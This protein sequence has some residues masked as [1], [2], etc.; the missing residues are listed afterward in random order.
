VNRARV[1]T[2][3]ALLIALSISGVVLA[4]ASGGSGAVPDAAVT[5]PASSSLLLAEVETGGASASDEFVEVTNAGAATADLVGLEVAYV[6]ST[7]GTITRKAS[8]ASSRPLA[9]GQHLLIA[10]A[11][12]IYGSLADV[13]YSGGLAAT[14]GALVLRPIGGAPIDAIAWGDA[15]NAFVEG[16]AAPAPAASASIEREPGG[17]DGNTT[18]TNSNVADWF[19]Q[20]IPNPQSLS[21]PPVPAP[22]PSATPTPTPSAGASPSTTPAPTDTPA[23]SPTASA[24]SSAEPSATPEPSPSPTAVP[25]PTPVPTPTVESTL[26]PTP[27]ATPEPTQTPAPT[28]APTPTPI[29]TPI[30]TD[31]PLPSPTPV[32]TDIAAVRLQA[33]GTTATVQGVLTTQ[34]GALEAGRKA[35]IQDATAGIALYLD[36]AVSDGLAAGTS[37]R[38]TGTLDDRYAERTLRANLADVIVLGD[39]T[40]PTPLATTSGSIGEALE[41]TRVTVDGLTVGSPSPLADG[42]GILVD[43]GSGA[44]RAI[45]GSEALGVAVL[46]SG[47]HVQVT[48]P[49]GQH[50][51]S[52]TGTT[53]Y[54]IHVTLAGELVVLPAPT[55]SP[56]PTAQPTATPSPTAAPSP[57]PTRTATPTSTPTSTLSPTPVPTPTPTATSTPTSSPTPAPTQTPTPTPVAMSIRNARSA[58]V[59]SLVTVE[60]VVTAEAGRL[61]TPP[62]FAIADPTGGIVIRLPDGATA[63]GRGTTVRVTGSTADPYGQLEIRPAATAFRITGTGVPPA[64]AVVTVPD[65]GEDTEGRLVSILGTVKAAPTKGTS[66][67]LSIDVVDASGRAFRAAVDGSSGIKATDIPRNVTLRLVGVVGQ[68]ASRK[69]A[70]DGYRIWLRDRADIAI[71]GTGGPSATPGAAAPVSIAAA[72]RAPDGTSLTIEASV[73]AGTSLLDASGRR[74]V[75]QDASGAIEVLLPTGAA[76]PTIGAH[77]RVTGEKAHAW[78]APRIKASVVSTLPAGPS[79]IPAA[80]ATTLG[81]ADEWRLVGLSGTVLSVK[82]IGDR[83]QAEIRLPNGDRIPILGQAGAGIPSTTI[84]EGRAATIVGI[85]R[86]PYPTATDR[87]FALLPRGRSDLALGPGPASGGSSGSGGAGSAGQTGGASSS[88]GASGASDVTPDTDLATL[89]EHVGSQ[90]HVGGLVTELTADGFLLDDGTAIARIVLHGDALVLLANIRVGEA[91]AARGTVEQDGETLLIS[92]ASASDLVRVGDLGQALPLASG[93]SEARSATPEA[94]PHAPSL[95]GAGAIDALPAQLSVVTLAAISGLSVLVTLLRRRM[96]AQRSRVLVL[97]RLATLTGHRTATGPARSAAAGPL[98]AGADRGHE[99]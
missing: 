12:G 59:G 9:S 75:V 20:A 45:V 21:A 24:A 83:W 27:T 42:L 33:D 31:T 43:D 65:L 76:A 49:V 1:A 4:A 35:F 63:P 54:R 23:P 14:G 64:P 46:P 99:A 28:L 37:V 94:S 48:G 85:V 95:V 68:H 10:N 66:G 44:V 77:L 56:S 13:T 15:T 6:T 61:G 19:V 91:L 18:D 32:V 29:P 79:I 67:D 88:A 72:L 96:A 69:G 98:R 53:A 8:W 47:T 51:S 55:L 3:A 7:G 41:G 25:T 17:L 50:D 78:G 74:M 84:I 36:A 30:P 86:R 92:V 26:E 62:L 71:V 39:G 22:G 34:L 82:R 90:V 5:W 89:F 40:L 70:L 73:T 81:E 11:S 57:M 16:T 87:R 38:V 80:R 60:G 52:G 97:A 58:A 93:A 2:L